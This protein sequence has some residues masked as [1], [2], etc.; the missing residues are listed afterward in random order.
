MIL[1]CSAELH[2]RLVFHQT[3]NSASK[4]TLNQTIFARYLEWCGDR[5]MHLI[6]LGI[7]IALTP[8]VLAVVWLLWQAGH[9][10]KSEGLDADGMI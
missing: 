8:S 6:L 2:A 10:E 9:S 5:D 1:Q 3:K 4:R 7:F